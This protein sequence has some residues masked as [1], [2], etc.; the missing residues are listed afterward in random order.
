MEHLHTFIDQGVVFEDTFIET[1]LAVLR[2]EGFMGAFGEHAEEAKQLLTAM[3]D[4][5]KGHREGLLKL[6][7]GLNDYGT[8]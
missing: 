3:I 2:D 6:K 5:S 8:T 4:E 1:Y 7:E